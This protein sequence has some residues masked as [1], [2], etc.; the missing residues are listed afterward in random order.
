MALWSFGSPLFM[1]AI[2]DPSD[3][4]AAA[5]LQIQDQLLW[6]TLL[7]AAFTLTL[8]VLLL[9]SGLK[10]VRSQPDGIRWSNRYAWLSIATKMISLLLTVVYVLP[11]TNRLMDE[12]LRTSPGMPSGAADQMGG[13]MKTFTSVTSVVTPVIA[14]LYPSLALYFLSRQAVKT[15][16]AGR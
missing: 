4:S 9:V 11:I 8:A 2:L 14:C 12:I 15:W 5:Q 16:A 7:T 13:M 1:K 6:I 3:P 10:L